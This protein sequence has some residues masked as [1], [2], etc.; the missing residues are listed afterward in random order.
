[1]FCSPDGD[2]DFF[3]IVPGVLQ[4]DTFVPYLF[5]LYQ[6]YV[7][8]ASTDR[9]KRKRFHMKK[10]KKQSETMTN[11]GYADDVAQIYQPKY[12]AGS[13]EE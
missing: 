7:L 1:M 8:R 11:A 5:V 6:N 13:K 10:G 3:N 9:T 4:E 2:A 12:K